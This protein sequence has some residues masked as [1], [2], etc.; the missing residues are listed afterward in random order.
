MLTKEGNSIR[1]CAHDLPFSQNG[2][3]TLPADNGTVLRKI[4]GLV[5]YQW[6]RNKEYRDSSIT[7]VHQQCRWVEGWTYSPTD[8]AR[9]RKKQASCYEQPP[10][11]WGRDDSLTLVTSSFKARGYDVVDTQQSSFQIEV[12]YPKNDKL[13]CQR[14]D[15][16]PDQYLTEPGSKPE[17]GLGRELHRD[18]TRKDWIQCNLEPPS[19]IVKIPCFGSPFGLEENVFLFAQEPINLKGMLDGK[20]PL[21][22]DQLSSIVWTQFDY[23]WILPDRTPYEV[24]K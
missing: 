20:V 5:L 22:W 6:L 8:S 2:C 11:S 4:R 19:I 14:W 23:Y 1:I 21:S 9:T 24:K 15:V 7:I 16:Y 3:R 12:K 18:E 13:F 17:S 10:A